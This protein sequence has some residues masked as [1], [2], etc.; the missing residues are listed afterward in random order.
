M[1]WAWEGRRRVEV[2]RMVELEGRILGVGT[3]LRAEN[4]GMWGKYV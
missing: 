3:G 2:R 1:F 4:S